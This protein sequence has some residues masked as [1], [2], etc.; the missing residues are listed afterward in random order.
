MQM[1]F[2]LR[3]SAVVTLSSILLSGWLTPSALAFHNTQNGELDVTRSCSGTHCTILDYWSTTDQQGNLIAPVKLHAT[4]SMDTILKA[5]ASLA[6]TCAAGET[7]TIPIEASGEITGAGSAFYDTPPINFKPQGVFQAMTA[8]LTQACSSTG[9]DYSARCRELLN[10]PIE[11][12]WA[13]SWTISGATAGSVVCSS[14]AAGTT[15]TCVVAPGTEGTITAQLARE[16]RDPRWKLDNT[17]SRMGRMVKTQSPPL[18]YAKMV[19]ATQIICT[20][21]ATPNL[22]VSAVS[23]LPT[24]PIHNDGISVNATVENQGTATAVA[25]ISRLRFD[26]DADGSW[27]VGPFNVD[28][29]ALAASGTTS[30]TWIGAWTAPAGIHRVEV[31]ADATNAVVESDEHDNCSAMVFTVRKPALACG[32]SVQ[33]VPLNEPML[34]TA[35]GGSSNQAFYRWAAP[36][37]SIEQGEGE[38]FSATYSTPGAKTAGVIEHYVDVNGD[39]FATPFDGQI[40]LNNIGKT[41]AG[42]GARW[43]NQVNRFDVNGDGFATRRDAQIANDYAIE[44]GGGA[45]PIVE[46]AITVAP[47]TTTLAP[48]PATLCTPATQRVAV[49]EP[50]SL[51]YTLEGEARWEAVGGTPPASASTREFTT[52][53]A[54]PGTYTVQAF[55]PFYYDVNGDGYATA[56]DLQMVA[57]KVSGT[58]TSTPTLTAKPWQNQTNPFDVNG[59]GAVTPQDALN[60]VNYIN[61]Y[62]TGALPLTTCTVTVAAAEAS[63]GVGPTADFTIPPTV[64]INDPIPAVSTSIVGT[65]TSGACSTLTPTWSVTRVSDGQVVTPPNSSAPSISVVGDTLSTYKFTLTVV[66]GLNRQSTATKYTQVVARPVEAGGDPTA[67]CTPLTQTAT[68]ATAVQLTSTIGDVSATWSAPEGTPTSGTGA[69]FSVSFA[70]AGTKSVTVSALVP[71]YVDVTGDGAITFADAV[72][73]SSNLGATSAPG[74][75]S[76]W[77]NQALKYDVNGDGAV[78]AQGDVLRLFNYIN[79]NGVGRLPSLECRVEVAAAAEPEQPSSAPSAAACPPRAPWYDVTGDGSVRADDQQAIVTALNSGNTVQPGTGAAPWQ[80]QVNRF[81]VDPS[82]GTVTPTDVRIVVNYLNAHGEGALPTC[83]V[84]PPPPPGGTG[85]TTGAPFNPGP[86]RETE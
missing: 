45:L 65:C 20:P 24:K 44:Y 52:A 53:Y 73:V 39:G 5:P 18:P 58:S 66:D 8:G 12:T 46:C 68:A 81:D 2:T 31:C 85:T 69:T 74:N 59:D 56:F 15:A 37:A 63:V 82:D 17:E 33:S 80:N 47:S 29:T 41:E 42:S 19:S 30:A 34:L 84:A 70:T 6:A 23:V 61:R 7:L 55:P 62:G 38:R 67:L 28:T 25:S 72:A 1:I 71:P 79:N 9:P 50:A 35:T 83:T 14:N 86:I 77:Q 11:G 49:N 40:A 27:D 76:P 10:N 26:K 13:D 21:P 36:G 57:A 22:S 3:I 4:L 16:V 60:I 75:G 64:F 48:P 78:T 51:H 54:T 43:Q 32:P